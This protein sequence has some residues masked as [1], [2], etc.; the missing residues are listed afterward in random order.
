MW[1]F[2]YTCEGISVC[3]LVL[4]HPDKGGCFAGVITPHHPPG[5]HGQLIHR[6]SHAHAHA[7]AHTHT[8][9]TSSTETNTQTHQPQCRGTHVDELHQQ[10]LQVTEGGSGLHTE[11]QL[12]L[13]VTAKPNL[14]GQ[15]G[16]TQGQSQLK[17]TTER[18][19]GEVHVR[20]MERR[21]LFIFVDPNR[22][23]LYHCKANGMR[24]YWSCILRIKTLRLS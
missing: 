22:M 12:L 24:M 6:L 2:I 21:F 1:T 5:L 8:Q 10:R 9:F 14:D 15:T 3:L 20:H 18:P 16:H 13:K 23:V 17:K 7:H 11:A 19:I 4:T